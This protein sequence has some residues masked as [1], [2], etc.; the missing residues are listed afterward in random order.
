M[1]VMASGLVY[2]ALT[3]LLFRV[4]LPGLTTHLASDVG[5]PLMIV[6]ILEWNAHHV[7]LTAA[8]WNVPS[9]APLQGVTAFTEHFLLAYPLASPI[10][11][12]TG[13][14]VLAY[15]VVFLLAWPVNALAGYALAREVTGSSA[16]AF[17]G[18]LAFGFAPYLANHVSHLQLLLA[19][20]M[21]LGLLGLHRYLRTRR[22]RD[23][24]LCGAGWLATAL[25]SAYTLVFF[26]ILVVLWCA[27]C[28]RPREWRP[29]AAPAIAALVAST[30]LIPLLAG[31]SAR[32]ATLGLTRSYGESKEW[33]ADMT[34]LIGVSHR[35]WLWSHWLPIDYGE[36]SIF[37]GVTIVALAV[38]AVM[39]ACGASPVGL[40]RAGLTP[41]RGSAASAGQARPAPQEGEATQRKPWSRRLLVSAVVLTLIVLA[42][43]W[44]GPSG[45]PLPPFRPYRA[46]TL[47]V[48]LLIA[49]L[50]MS[51]RCRANWNRRD[52]VMFYAVASVTFWLMALGPEPTWA[53]ARILTYGPYRLFFELHAP[54]V[55]RV[56][57]RAWIVVLPSLA[58]L[59]AFGT[60]VLL[61]RAPRHRNL[62]VAAIAALIVAESWFV[63]GT[64]AVPSPMPRGSI[65]QGAIVLDVPFDDPFVNAAAQYRAVV[66]GYRTINGYSGYEAPH[67]V[68][69]TKAFKDG[70]YSAVETYRQSEDLY[71]IV[72]P[73][74]DPSFVR[75]LASQSLDRP[76]DTAGT[77][78]YRL[79]STELR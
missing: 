36:S 63:D 53:G 29:L 1:P 56:S 24:A 32:Q 79:R 35:E 3:A 41:L 73:E 16:A 52:P 65:P 72:R 13:N 77:A 68:Q 54:V 10:I 27:W 26:P 69:L 28:V 50:F 15:N 57:A 8:W 5:D 44:V 74:A 70:Q 51:E 55:V 48:V 62:A 42:R 30:A 18:G 76:S 7:P 2:A 33:A 6:A 47:A 12:L 40:A 17:I 38:L 64:Q 75:W 60:K 21:P 22:W 43:V 45:W 58:V 11:W 39:R 59:A 67:L 31:Y 9:F 19:F 34:A 14:P 37:P 25:A 20:G 78:V 61:D 23:A 71:V 4:L 66:G 46:F 49:A